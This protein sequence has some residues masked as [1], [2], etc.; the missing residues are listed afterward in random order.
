MTNEP[1]KNELALIVSFSRIKEN[2][3]EGNPG[4]SL[5]ATERDVEGKTGGGLGG[6]VL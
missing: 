6:L 4:P 3:K 5:Y 2:M 1:K